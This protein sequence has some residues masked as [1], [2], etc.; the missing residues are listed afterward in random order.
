VLQDA[1]I[2]YLDNITNAWVLDSG[3]SF[4]AKSHRK[5]FQDYVQGDFG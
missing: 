3:S 2:I 5:Y 4:H 1:L